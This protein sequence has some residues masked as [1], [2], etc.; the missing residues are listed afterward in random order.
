MGTAVHRYGVGASRAHHKAKRSRKTNENARLY[1]GEEARE[2]ASPR[3]ILQR[4]IDKAEHLD[5]RRKVQI[6]VSLCA[7]VV[8]LLY[9]LNARLAVLMD[10]GYLGAFLL[11]GISNMT[12]ILPT[13]AGASVAVMAL[14]LDPLLLGIAAGVGGTLGGATAYM[15]GAFHR[16]A[17][18]CGGSDWLEKTMGRCGGAIVL[19]FSAVPFLPGDLAGVVAGAARYPTRRYLLFAGAGNVVKMA[20]VAYLGNNLLGWLER[21]LADWVSAML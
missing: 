16:K 3:D 8:L 4:L 20:V 10:W 15:L 21:S 2:L 18:L 12:I 17:V 19:L 1:M 14:E 6:S 13:P 9:L 11:N 5:E 7:S